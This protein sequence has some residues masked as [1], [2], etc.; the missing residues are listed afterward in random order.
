MIIK[1]Y[2]DTSLTPT[3][4]TSLIA[5]YPCMKRWW[6]YDRGFTAGASATWT[7]QI[8][9]EVASIGS[10]S[11]TLGSSGIYGTAGS[12]TSGTPAAS[13]FAPTANKFLFYYVVGKAP[14]GSTALNFDYAGVVSGIPVASHSIRATGLIST[15]DAS[16]TDTSATTGCAAGTAVGIAAGEYIAQGALV[17][18]SS[19]TSTRIAMGGAS[20]SALV[21][22]DLTSNAGTPAGTFNNIVTTHPQSGDTTTALVGASALAAS[23]LG[24]GTGGWISQCG[25]MQFANDPGITFLQAALA[26]M[27]SNPNKLYPGLKG[28]AA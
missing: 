10:G 7:D 19:N 1:P 22:A 28:K 8:A 16:G 6:V 25:I 20:A 11:L 13:R 15:Q 9:G 2:S 27:S 4:A 26:W 17:S 5:D 24:G 12:I 3:S 21:A 23:P 18:M 14:T